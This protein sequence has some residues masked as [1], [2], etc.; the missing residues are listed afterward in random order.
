MMNLS[1]LLLIS[2]LSP[3]IVFLDILENGKTNLKGIWVCPLV[4][5]VV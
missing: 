1:I 2:A 4:V 3:I 5:D